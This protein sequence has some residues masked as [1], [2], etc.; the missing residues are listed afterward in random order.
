ML[1]LELGVLPQSPGGGPRKPI[2]EGDVTNSTAVGVACP[3][4]HENRT[5][6][7]PHPAPAS[8][9]QSTVS[10]VSS[11]TGSSSVEPSAESGMPLKARQSGTPSVLSSGSDVDSDQEDASSVT[12]GEATPDMPF[13]GIV[14]VTTRNGNQ[15]EERT[16]EDEP[17]THSM[18]QVWSCHPTLMQFF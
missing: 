7:Q 10:S 11:E 17:E 15:A 13:Y 14:S 5:S 12:S 18:S 16:E 2:A 3:K 8:T 6:L 1:S 4:V 9:P